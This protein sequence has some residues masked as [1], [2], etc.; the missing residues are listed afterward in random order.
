[1]KQKC[2]FL[3]DGHAVIYRGFFGFK[4][5]PM[6][7]SKGVDTGA[8]YS[9][10]KLI[11]TLLKNYNMTHMGVIF[12]PPYRTWRKDYYPEYKAGRKHEDDVT[13]QLEMA[14]H[15]IKT[16]GIFT[17]AY[18]PLEADDVLGILTK[19]AVAEGFKV[20]IATK[21]KDLMQLISDTDNVSML[22][23]GKVVGK[24]TASFINEQGVIDRFNVRADQIVDFLTLVGDKVDNVPGVKGCGKKGAADLLA[25]YDTLDNIFLHTDEM[26]KSK[27]ANFESSR[28]TVK[29]D[30]H[31]IEL[32]LR[33]SV[34]IELD[35]LLVPKI[36]NKK[37]FELFD[38]LEFHS[39]VKVLSENDL[40]PQDVP[41]VNITEDQL[42]F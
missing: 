30:K 4:N 25:K 2:L 40:V 19:K 31:L 32:A 3:L 27:K 11:A 5:S 7:T 12:D 38:E 33:Y 36:H 14:Y 8:T 13:P 20:V 37:L 41:E 22:D 16:W 10:A 29:R 34:P 1:M 17:G 15:M 21:D 23:L 24:D 26:T 9:M 39:I 35:N 18:R 6:I 42:P 28:T